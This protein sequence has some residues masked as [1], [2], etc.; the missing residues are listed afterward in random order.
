MLEFLAW[1]SR[2]GQISVWPHAPYRLA[3]FAPLA[4]IAMVVLFVDGQALSAQ[5]AG[6]PNVVLILADD[7]GYGDVGFNGCRDIPTPNIDSLADDGVRFANGYSSH[8]F[9]S[10]MRAGL[11][12]GKYQHRF[13]YVNNVAFDP[14]NQLMGLPKSERTIAS[15]LQEAGYRTGMVGKW[16]LGAASP[17]HP[18]RRGFEFFYGFLGG[19]HDYFIVDTA[20]QLSENYKAALDDNG[21]PATLDGYLTNVLTDQ[22]IRFLELSDDDRPY[23][24][25]VAYN[26]PH[27]PLQAPQE[28]IAQFSSIQDPRRRTYAAMV[29]VMDQ[30]IGR[31]LQ[32]ID[33]IGDRNNTLVVFLSDNGGP[34]KA[35]A[36]DNGPLRGQKGDVHEGGI[37]VP[38]VMRM[39]GTLPAATVYSH[40]VISLDAAQTAL[41]LAKVPVEENADGVNLI[42]FVLDQ[43]ETAPHEAIFWRTAN[44]AKIAVRRGND[45][46][47]VLDG[48]PSLFDLASDLGESSDMASAKPTMVDE[49]RQLWNRWNENN[50]PAIFPGYRD[51]HKSLVEFHQ[52]LMQD[53]ITADQE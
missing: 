10:P 52:Q 8:P 34:E 31:L 40:P 6:R 28:A 11:M 32:T 20:A 21:N 49:I 13:G 5:S 35:N 36:S 3:M 48:E 9:C 33:D 47:V 30:Q 15:R 23:F 2:G 50:R 42:P 45:K 43:R 29:S 1:L 26:A 16:H 44:D 46:L 14:H 19:G 25:Y 17:F 4:A 7:L 12:T 38:F 39:P 53:A 27:G 37:H 41:G 51:Y 24:L 18:L 22:A